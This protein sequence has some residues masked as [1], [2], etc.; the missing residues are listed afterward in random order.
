MIPVFFVYKK[1][2]QLSTFIVIIYR[3]YCR[4]FFD[5]TKHSLLCCLWKYL[6]LEYQVPLAQVL[7]VLLVLLVLLVLQKDMYMHFRPKFRRYLYKFFRLRSFLLFL[8]LF[9]MYQLKNPI[10]HHRLHKL[11]FLYHQTFYMSGFLHPIRHHQLHKH[12]AHYCYQML[13]HLLT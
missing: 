10:H 5:Q 1:S 11:L 12:L 4:D 2:A 7:Q 9:Y 6:F 13:Y 3:I 8:L